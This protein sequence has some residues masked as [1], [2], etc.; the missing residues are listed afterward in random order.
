MRRYPALSSPVRTG[1]VSAILALHAWLAIDATIDLGVTSD[2]T[3]HLTGGYS[4]W[5]YNDYRLHP[6]NGNLPQ[7]WAAIPLLIIR[8]SLNLTQ[9]PQDW[10]TADVW[11]MGHHFFFE[12][13]NNID[14]LMLCGRSMMLLWSLA[15]GFLIFT[16]SRG[17]WG[18]L[19]GIF[20]LTLF[21]FSPTTLAHAPLI[22][23]DMCAAF[24]LLAATGAW[25]RL[26]ER[27]T[28]L[29]L[30]LSVAATSLAVAAKF[31]GLLL[32]PIA[33]GIVIWRMLRCRSEQ[34]TGPR[35]IWMMSSSL[36]YAAGWT[37]LV[38]VHAIVSALVIWCLF[39]FRF[40]A[41]ND[42]FGSGHFFSDLQATLLS[43]SV[44]R[45]P[46]AAVQKLHVLPEA[47]IYG[48]SYVLFA[49]QKRPAFA[50]DQFSDAG[51]WWFFPF[52]FLVKS[53]VA[54]LTAIFACICAGITVAW[55]RGKTSALQCL[56]RLAPLVCLVAVYGLISISSHLN[57]GQRHLLPLYPV[58]FIAAGGLCITSA[59]GR[60]LALAIAGMAGV[61]SMSIRPDYLAFFNRLAGGPEAGWRL[62]VDSSLDWGQNLPKLAAVLPKETQKDERVYFAYFGSDDLTYRGIRARE[63][64]SYDRFPSSLGQFELTAGVYCVTATM[65]QDVYSPFRGQ[66][67]LERER[68]YRSL[69]HAIEETQQQ[70]GSALSFKADGSRTDLLLW[71]LE[72][73]RFA[74]LCEYLRIKEPEISI[75]HSIFVFRLN[76]HEIHT[77]TH[78]TLRE[79]ADMIDEELRLKRVR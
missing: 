16:W 21:A 12:S 10:Q 59:G 14:F 44:G 61:E 35:Q 70:R 64:A 4:Y 2:E 47:F 25:W 26:S 77:A 79:M 39:G 46:L 55:K 40:T 50:A 57:I 3:A 53:S 71:N 62:L 74:R 27:F 60:W 20:S 38:V 24:W 69:I 22:T 75:G 30:G 43:T 34:Q 58:L 56:D 31:S 28:L 23:S 52:A 7:R 48:L 51:W 65:L 6:E 11:R 5:L 78:G 76:E 68:E 29:R 17:L 49:A 37:G 9:F 18:D 1:L 36:A 32:F 63:L 33:I 15:T 41:F 73:A 54:E 19:G 45:W 72:R 66:W 13:G 42:A 67:S 8:P